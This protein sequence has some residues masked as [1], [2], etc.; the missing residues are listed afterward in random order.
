MGKLQLISG[1]AVLV[2]VGFFATHFFSRTSEQADVF[3]YGEFAGVSLKLEF[4]TTTAAREKGLS[5]RTLIPEGYG[6][7][8]VF[9]Q[10]SRYG[11]WMKDTLVPL[12]IFWLDS[13]GKV[14]SIHEGVTPESYPSVFYPS[15]PARYV[16]ETAAGFGALHAVAT[17]TP[18]L[19]KSW[20]IVSN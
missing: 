11:F 5:E 2:C 9:P 17:G 6:M 7:L 20:P 1:F 18:L 19:L 4:A 3:A 12:D 15:Q 14:V 16:L 13:T 10:D 8:F